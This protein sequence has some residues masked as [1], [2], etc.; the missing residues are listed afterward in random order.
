MRQRN[1]L[2]QALAT[3]ASLQGELDDQ[4]ELIELAESE[5]DEAV[6]NEAA[7]ALH[8]LKRQADQLALETLLS[9]ECLF[10]P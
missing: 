2:E 6:A 5:D 8:A 3:Y 7:D 10:R 9:G 1:R 4:I